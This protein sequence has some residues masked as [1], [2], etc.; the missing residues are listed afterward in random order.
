MSY[1][2]HTETDRAEMLKVIGVN[3]VED[4]FADVPERVRFPRLNLPGPLSEME[5]LRE[6]MELADINAHAQRYPLFLGAGVYNHF[7]PSVVNHMLL[8]G[9]FLTAYTPYQPEISQ[10]TLQVIY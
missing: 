10:G 6:L 2:P 5:T 3:R 9:E 8:R 7:S 1:Y 4:L